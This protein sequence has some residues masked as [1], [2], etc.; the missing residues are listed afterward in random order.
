MFSEKYD[1]FIFKHFPEVDYA[2]AY[3]SGAFEQVGNTNPDMVDFVFAVSN[4]TAWH[5]QN[6]KKNSTHYSTIMRYAGGNKVA[7]L[8][9]DYGAKLYYNTLVPLPFGKAPF[10]KYG[11][12]E[13]N[14]LIDDLA[15]WS[16]LYISGRMHKP[17]SY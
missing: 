15:N 11:V 1:N 3:G 12:I 13:T 9:R 14:D 7:Y 17:V 8:Q 10:I 4:S 5:D 2:F 6:I 16:T